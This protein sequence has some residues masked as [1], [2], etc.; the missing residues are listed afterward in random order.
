[1][2]D[3][4]SV[5]SPHER[6][7][8][9]L[10]AEYYEA[11][12]L[13]RPLDQADFLRQHPDFSTELRDFFAD[14]GQI[15]QVAPPPDPA[16]EDTQPV[17]GSVPTSVSPGVKVRNFG[18]YEILDEL[19]AG[20]MGVVY[21]A[22][23]SKLKK[24]VA[25]K[26]IKVGHLAS[27]EDVRRFQAEARA[28]AKLDHPGIVP[29]HEVG[30][31][32]GQHYYAMDF[33]G[34]GSLSQLHRDEPV[35]S[36]RAAELVKQL[37]EAMHYAHSRGIVHRDLKPAN[38]L[39]TTVG[40]P[41]ITDFGLAKRMWPD[42]DSAGV[43]M[44]Q[45]GQILGTAGYMSPE[46]AA[47]KTGLVGP[48]ADTYALGAV[49]YALL[50]SRA[51]FVGESQADTI[52]QVIN[53]EPVSPRV[54]N[55]SVPRDLETICLKC[56][57]KEPPKRY[58]SAQLLADDLARFVGGRPVLARPVGH[59]AH[60]WRWC[61]RNPWGATA[62]AL[63]ML[64]AVVSPPVA[65]AMKGLADAEYAAR[66]TSDGLVAEKTELIG[67]K[68]NL[69]GQ[70]NTSL[71]TQRELTTQAKT[72]LAGEVKAKSELSATL[73]DKE[74]ALAEAERRARQIARRNYVLLLGQAPELWR[75]ARLAELRDLLSEA[76]AELVDQD[77][78]GAAYWAA[79]L[80][81]TA[82]LASLPLFASQQF[83][84]SR[85]GQRAVCVQIHPEDVLKPANV[86]KRHV[87]ELYRVIH[88]PAASPPVRFEHQRQVKLPYGSHRGI[89]ILPDGKRLAITALDGPE[90]HL[91]DL[92]E[93]DKSS[94]AFKTKYTM[95]GTSHF[96]ATGS[97]FLKYDG[98]QEHWQ[99]LS[100]TDGTSQLLPKQD[101]FVQGTHFFLSDDGKLIG[102]SSG[103]VLKVDGG[104]QVARF[105]NHTLTEGQFSPDNR[106]LSSRGTVWKLA[107]GKQILQVPQGSRCTFSRTNPDLAFVV[108][109]G[110]L[111]RLD[112]NRGK[113][114]PLGTIGNVSNLALIPGDDTLVMGTLPDSVA[115]WS[116]SRPSTTSSL[117]LGPI[118]ALS[119]NRRY[120]VARK[121][122]N[123]F[124]VWDL[125]ERKK[126]ADIGPDVQQHAPPGPFNPALAP[127]FGIS[128]EALVAY[129]FNFMLGQVTLFDAKQN[130]VL[131]TWQPK[132]KTPPAA[133]KVASI[134]PDG[135]TV[136]LGEAS[137]LHGWDLKTRQDWTLMP[138][139]Y[140]GEFRVSPDSQWL[141]W[142]DWFWSLRD[143]KKL[144]LPA[145]MTVSASTDR[146]W[147][148]LNEEIL[149]TGQFGTFFNPATR[150]FRSF[151]TP[152]RQVNAIA[153]SPD[154][155]NLAVVSG[156]ATGAQLRVFAIAEEEKPSRLWPVLE[157]ETISAY[158]CAFT[159]D[160]RTLLLINQGGRVD[161]IQ[162][163]LAPG[164]ALRQ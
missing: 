77:E 164:A 156:V 138:G 52:L 87:V 15:E 64:V 141:I 36:R 143:R 142:R 79:R 89:V 65:I 92:E 134:T 73:K 112:L 90:V 97:H 163:K 48:P 62:A 111:H 46:Q 106:F 30:V 117:Q 145:S 95:Y 135:K 60:G 69:I 35:A 161:Y 152:E 22:R 16:L 31:H 17:S 91:I 43:S 151:V 54:L 57:E 123:V 160:S 27:N 83:I 26:M 159:P 144:Q 24:I 63:V 114:T 44:T 130:K 137:V 133:M 9:A 11:E 7:L 75:H 113:S 105:P 49:L 139:P 85:D 66:Q 140:I 127:S 76:S 42:D 125:F 47:G 131:D 124:E 53:Q 51:P 132:V 94:L 82:P 88:D 59:L 93:S 33:V 86:Y 119:G 2:P 120:A 150:Q 21:K 147:V 37:A 107:D 146:H 116:T 157:L 154:G 72:A 58:V 3:Y 99:L 23:Q 74:R 126:L 45:S 19:G 100:L 5:R 155:R 34:G 108:A 67:D 96:S 149:L 98:D 32:Q 14:V 102:S 41:R 148:T 18:D 104:E 81:E 8:D 56:L 6:Q 50:T 28:A 78:F 12:E 39:L 84:F 129:T 158:Q 110:V 136:L 40:A 55:P 68:D 25:L 121:K 80:Q 38:V 115:A 71:A 118:Q 10:I 29:V 70:L 162:A 103:F 1:M 153:I 109:E 101:E 13:G 122:P 4:I 61:R 128:D 20:G